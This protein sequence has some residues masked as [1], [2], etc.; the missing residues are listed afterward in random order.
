M[1]NKIYKESIKEETETNINVLYSENK[2]IVYT[3]KVTLEKQLYKLL[4]EPNKEFKIKR[5]I[6]GSIWEISLNDKDKIQKLI[7][8]ANIYEL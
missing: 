6:A 1:K 7:L 5:S 2:L 8:K 3:N 4:G